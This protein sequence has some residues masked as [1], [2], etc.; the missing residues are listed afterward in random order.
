MFVP[1]TQKMIHVG[2]SSQPE[3]S[4]LFFFRSLSSVILQTGSTWAEQIAT[5]YTTD[6]EGLPPGRQIIHNKLS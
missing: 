2:G 5:R 1:I 4:R 3:S 6:G